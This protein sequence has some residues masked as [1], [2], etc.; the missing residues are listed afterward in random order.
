M[1]GSAPAGGAAPVASVIVLAFDAAASIRAALRS[2][3]R[4]TF[5]EPFEVIV[6][7]SGDDAT[8]E[9]AAAELP[10]AVVVG[11]RER[12]L[13]GAARNLGLAHARADLIVFL[14]ADCEAAANWLAQ[15]VADH[16]A[17]HDLVGG[18]VVWAEPAGACAR[19][20]HL[21]EYNAFPP[22]RPRELVDSP[23]YNLS[24][25]RSVL[26]RYGRYDETL[27]CGEDTALVWRLVAG[28]QRFLFDPAVRIAHPGSRSL[29]ELWRHQAW[30]GLWFGRLSRMRQVPGLGGNGGWRTARLV[31]AYPAGRLWRMLRRLWRWQPGWLVDSLVLAP[32]LLLGLTAA[33]VGLIRGLREEA[34]DPAA[35]VAGGAAPTSSSRGA[36]STPPR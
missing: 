31:A 6:V 24:F 4:Q 12:L 32:L 1:S 2:L 14:A 23:V 10:K 28:G 36:P 7:W 21:L 11:R 5:V 33:T 19:A 13:T 26:E 35:A 22:G 20:S 18:A 25:H 3:R 29:G 17:G 9:L 34:P 27:P 15:R 8:P 16:R 30:H